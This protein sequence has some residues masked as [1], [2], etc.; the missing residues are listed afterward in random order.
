MISAGVPIDTTSLLR[1]KQYVARAVGYPDASLTPESSG[2]FRL[3]DFGHFVALTRSAY[4]CL[5]GLLTILDS[6]HEIDS[7]SAV[8]AG[9]NTGGNSSSTVLIGT[10]FSDVSITLFLAIEELLTLPSAVLA[11][12]VE[13]LIVICYKHELESG[14]TKNLLAPLRRAVR[15]ASELMLAETSYEIKQ[16]ALSATQAFVRRNLTPGPFTWYVVRLVYMAILTY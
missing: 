8:T 14:L 13:A 10:V 4:T 2:E 6:S 11:N 9:N 7:Y 15:R 5:S 3:L 12:L 16:A 1:I